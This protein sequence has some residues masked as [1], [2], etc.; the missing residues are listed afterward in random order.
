MAPRAEAVENLLDLNSKDVVRV[1][2]I[3]GMGRDREDD[4]CCSYV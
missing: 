2:E 1:V 4:S 3:H